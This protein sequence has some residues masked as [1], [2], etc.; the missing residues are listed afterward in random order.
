MSARN[1][2][3][4]ELRALVAHAGFKIIKSCSIFPV[5]EVY[6]WLPSF[7]IPWYRGAIP[8]LERVPFIR[9]FGNSTLILA[10]RPEEAACV[11]ETA[12]KSQKG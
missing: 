8:V 4:G 3:P 5:F 9:R 10:Q 6:P 12:R 11:V 2:W 1:Y 7:L